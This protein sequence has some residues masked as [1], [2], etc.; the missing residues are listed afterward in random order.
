[1]CGIAGSF[2]DGIV[3]DFAAVTDTLRHRGP[4]GAGVWR[5]TE[6]RAVLIHTRLAILDLS[7]AGA[8]PMGHDGSPS[9]APIR[10]GSAALAA[11][12]WI[13]FNGEIYNFGDL[14]AELE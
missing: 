9:G 2:G 4:D 3:Q 6:S 1:M 12:Y 14:R 11:R 5:D 10:A 7:E 13:V 8:Q